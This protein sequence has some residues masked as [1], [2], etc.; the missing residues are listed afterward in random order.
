MDIQ[1]TWRKRSEVLG[2]NIEYLIF[3]KTIAP[4]IAEIRSPVTIGRSSLISLIVGFKKNM[5]M[6][7]EA[8]ILGDIPIA[9]GSAL[10]TISRLVHHKLSFP[11]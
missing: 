8:R 6:T 5:E 1:T 11:P 9:M 2:K 7:M 3:T 10:I 4:V